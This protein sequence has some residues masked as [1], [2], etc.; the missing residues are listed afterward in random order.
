MANMGKLNRRRFLASASLVLPWSIV[1]ATDR[2]TPPPLPPTDCHTHFYDPGRPEGVPWPPAGEKRLYRTVLPKDFTKVAG[3]CGIRQT[4]VVEASAWAADNQWVLDLAARSPNLVGLVGRLEPGSPGFDT[5][6]AKLSANPLF[7]GIRVSGEDV[8]KLLEP[9][10]L[11][12]IGRLSARGLTLDLNSGLE[13]LTVASELAHRLPNLKI[14]INHLTNLRIDGKTPP[15]DWLRGLETA[16]RKPNIWL[17]V[18][19]LVEGS[20][21]SDG[22]AP[23]DP[24]FYRPVLDAVWDHFGSRRL[25]FGS[26]WPVSELFAPYSTVHAIAQTYFKSRGTEAVEDVFA[27]SGR[28]AYGWQTHL[29]P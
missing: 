7:R 17:K 9:A 4:V 14:V 27:R 2:P 12:D 16:A 29:A 22:T 25:V 6:L 1:G 19:G 23:S 20:G 8:A 5:S 11:A 28:A 26:N 24:V 13:T 10:R 15:A 21:R 3:P 18:S